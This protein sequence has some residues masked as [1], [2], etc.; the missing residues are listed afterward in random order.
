MLCD[1]CVPSNGKIICTQ[2]AKEKVEAMRAERDAFA[3]RLRAVESTATASSEFEVSDLQAD[4]QAARAAEAN[5]RSALAEEAE[6]AARQAAAQADVTS[7]LRRVQVTPPLGRS[8]PP[9]VLC[10]GIPPHDV[11]LTKL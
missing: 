4:L 1:E 7:Q 11:L 2:V 10:I 5:A 6:N 8:C 3:E 9:Y